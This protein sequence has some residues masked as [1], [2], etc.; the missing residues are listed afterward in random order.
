MPSETEGPASR[1]D[2]FVVCEDA[3]IRHHNPRPRAIENIRG[4]FSQAEVELAAGRLLEFFRTSDEWCSF[5][6]QRLADFYA[7]KG[8]DANTMFFGLKG[9]YLDGGDT[10]RCREPDHI[11]IVEDAK[12]GELNITTAFIEQCSRNIKQAA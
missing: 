12:G 2:V 10:M 7:K 4:C 9:A 6:I 3:A 11:Y 5:S 1:T 8:W